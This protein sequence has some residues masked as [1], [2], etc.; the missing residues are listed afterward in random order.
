MQEFLNEDFLYFKK[1]FNKYP[2]MLL[3]LLLF[4][5]LGIMMMILPFYCNIS[6]PC[7]KSVLD[8]MLYS[9][10]LIC[11]F[12]LVFILTPLILRQ[13]V[14]CIYRKKRKFPRRIIRSSP[15]KSFR[16]QLDTRPALGISVW[17]S[18][19]SQD[20]H[21]TWRLLYLRYGMQKHTIESQWIV[22]RAEMEFVALLLYIWNWT[23]QFFYY[24][25]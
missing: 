6:Y 5:A 12:T 21:Y 25:A 1:K 7:S 3:T 18:R 17:A 4:I 11:L 8:F 9:G 15:L 13:W 10:T 2:S 24:T 23:S 22:N 16:Q 14:N 19:L 20:L